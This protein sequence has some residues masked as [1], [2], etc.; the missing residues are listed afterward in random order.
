MFFESSAIRS[1]NSSKKG[2]PACWNA[3]TKSLTFF[4]NCF[5]ELGVRSWCFVCSD[6]DVSKLF[7]NDASK[8]LTLLATSGTQTIQHSN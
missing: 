6:N 5:H 1:F 3:E 8:S 2:F 4:E 7:G